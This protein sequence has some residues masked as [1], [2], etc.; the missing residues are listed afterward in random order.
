VSVLGFI[1]FGALMGSGGGVCGGSGGAVVLGGSEVR[2]FGGSAGT[3]L[4]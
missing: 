3:R 2:W 4:G 1:F